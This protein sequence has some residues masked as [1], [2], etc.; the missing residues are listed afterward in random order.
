MPVVGDQLGKGKQCGNNRGKSNRQKSHRLSFSLTYGEHCQS[1][2][3]CSCCLDPRWLKP[4]SKHQQI[5]PK[6]QTC[7]GRPWTSCPSPLRRGVRALLRGAPSRANQSARRAVA[8]LGTA[9]W[10][11]PTIPFRSPSGTSACACRLL[12]KD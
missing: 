6:L 5:S 1:W 3:V 11:F 4:S 2:L 7:F 12:T 8:A 10:Q 9:T